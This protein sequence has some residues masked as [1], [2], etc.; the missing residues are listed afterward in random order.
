[1]QKILFLSYTATSE[2]YCLRV[3]ALTYE[4][5]NYLRR[6]TAGTNDEITISKTF[7]NTKSKKTANNKH[8]ASKK[9]QGHTCLASDY[10]H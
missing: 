2:I 9:T 6:C 5:R 8:K 4:V 7:Y 3:L 1:M 10:M